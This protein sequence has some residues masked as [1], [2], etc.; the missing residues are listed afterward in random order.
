[1]TAVI[2]IVIP[3]LAGISILLAIFL[4]W[5]ALSSRSRVTRLTYGVGR[6]E[7]RQAM[8]INIIRSIAAL[9]VGLILLG[10][11]GLSPTPTETAPIPTSTVPVAVEPATATVTLL[12]TA[13]LTLAVPTAALQAEPEG[14]TS[15]PVVAPPTATLTPVPTDTPTP[16]PPTARVTS[17]VGVWLRAAPSAQAEQ[18]ERLEDGALLILLPGRVTAEELEWQEV[19]APSG[20]EGWVAIPFI[21]YNE[22]QP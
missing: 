18:L 22:S 15:E 1:M 17:E 13:T 8:Q 16:P 10:V 21:A 2:N 7:A 11:W 14:E 6:Q 4:A 5:R 19:R 20:N 12:P 3:F 9:F